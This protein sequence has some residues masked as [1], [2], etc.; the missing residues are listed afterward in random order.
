MNPTAT[1]NTAYTT[2]DPPIQAT[3]GRGEI[4][5]E[6]EML[7]G[8]EKEQG[9]EGREGEGRAWCKYVYVT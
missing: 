6:Q 2:I 3:K 7:D 8:D 5:Q 4:M 9:E 1:G